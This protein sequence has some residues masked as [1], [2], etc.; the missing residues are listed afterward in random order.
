MNLLPLLSMVMAIIVM[1][2]IA[3]GVLESQVGQHSILP[4]SN[5]EF[6]K[7]QAMTAEDGSGALSRDGGRS[8][9]QF[10]AMTLSPLE[11]N[12]L[13]GI[14]KSKFAYITLIHGIDN[15]FTYRGFLY[16]ALIMKKALSRLGSTA[17][18]IVML[19][20]TTLGDTLDYR[21]FSDD[22][23]LLKEAGMRI[24][25]L[26]RLRPV[27]RKVSFTEMALLKITPWNLTEYDKIQYF[28]GDILPTKNM[29]CFFKYQI[30]T[31]N[32]GNASPLNSGWFLA[33]PNPRVF[34]A[35][36][37]KSL[38]RLAAPWD[39]KSGWG[40]AIPSGV[41]FRGGKPVKLWNFNGASLDQGLLFD[42]Y[43]LHG[44]VMLLDTSEGLRYTEG[45]IKKEQLKAIYTVSGGKAPSK[46]FAH[47]TGRSKPWLQNLDKTKVKIIASNIC[48]ALQFIDS[49]RDVWIFY[50]SPFI[51]F[52]SVI[53]SYRTSF[54]I[55]CND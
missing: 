21:L 11:I 10:N 48:T 34:L 1:L 52:M 2:V 53:V 28:D 14:K 40:T 41:T 50:I 5:A 4:G 36:R 46:C 35:M 22:I 42:T 18:F 12:V 7:S 51:S 15:T 25:Y 6:H 33:I 37:E 54:V 55:S 30:D 31:F 45:K 24:F 47:F 16:N 38:S 13:L 3:L 23:G 20:F 49:V 9:A 29:D 17:D 32:T 39:Q 26:P 44:T 43:A 27:H 8:R 19:G